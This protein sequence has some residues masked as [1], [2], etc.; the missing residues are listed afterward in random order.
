MSPATWSFALVCVEGDVGVG[1]EDVPDEAGPLVDEPHAATD[2]A[3]TAA[4]T[5]MVY[6]MAATIGGRSGVDLR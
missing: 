4:T 5:Q 6:R 2:T 3:T 1:L